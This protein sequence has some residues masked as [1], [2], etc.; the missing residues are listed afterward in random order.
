MEPINHGQSG[1][2]NEAPFVNQKFDTEMKMDDSL[3]SSERATMDYVSV[4]GIKNRTGAAEHQL[5]LYMLKELIDNGLD[6]IDRRPGTMDIANVPEIS[7]TIRKENEKITIRVSNSDFGLTALTSYKVTNIFNFNDFFSSKRN[8]YK[9]N[10]G[11]L[12]DALKEVISIPLA[13]A[14]NNDIP[15]WNEP[16]IIESGT[17]TFIVRMVVDK[18][19][20]KITT[21]VDIKERITDC[22][23]IGFTVVQVTLPAIN[24][25]DLDIRSF[26][27]NYSL[28]NT[29]VSFNFEIFLDAS[30]KVQV[31]YPAC[32]KL[33]PSSNLSSI[34]YYTLTEFRNLILGLD[35]NTMPAYV[36]LQNF[37]EGNN[38]KKQAVPETIGELKSKPARIK[39]IF[40]NLRFIMKATSRA[41]IPF[42]T[43]KKERERALIDRTE[44]LGYTVSDIKY[45]FRECNYNGDEIKFPFLVEVAIISVEQQQF[46]L[47]YV[48]GTNCSH[49][50]YFT[51]LNGRP[52]TFI[53]TTKSGKIHNAGNIFELLE[54]YGYSY[55]ED[56]CRQPGAIVYIN[57]ISP[58]FDYQNYGKT[59]IDLKP[60][61]GT[62]AYILYK[63][64]SASRSSTDYYE[65]DTAEGLLT[66]LLESRL[67]GIESEPSLIKTDRWTQ[68][69]VYYRL[70]PQLIAKGIDVKRKYITSQIRKVCE[71]RLGK[72]R[73]ELGIVAADR[74]QLY[75]R[76]QWYDVGL[77][78]LEKLMHFG[79]DM[80]IIEKE[81][82]A[83]VLSPYAEKMGIALLNTRGFL[84][85][86]ATMLSHL[87]KKNGCNVAILTDFDVSGLLLARKVSDVFRIGIDFET[88]N[89]FGLKP[90]DVEERY[91]A[92][93]NHM[94][95]LQEMGP[96]DGEEENIFYKNLEYISHKR[97]EIDSVLAKVGNERFWKYLIQKIKGRFSRRNYN[98]SIC[99][100]IFVMPE[101]V[102]EFIEKMKNKITSSLM[103]E[104]ELIEHEFSNF[105]GMIDDVREKEE[106]I[107]KRFKTKMSNDEELQ[108]I[109]EKIQELNDEI[110]TIGE[111]GKT[112]KITG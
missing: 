75:F 42:S 22:S 53:W 98:R 13:I 97:I 6:F 74:A 46:N 58:R 28:L 48:E 33:I 41:S 76:G 102:I 63:V 54:K 93:N 35:D 32:Q 43:C 7:I 87:S 23:N 21:A 81:G 52:Q 34:H 108:S 62:I 8:Q 57:L 45:G 89:Y 55:N 30:E 65:R 40:Q 36:I 78:E 70:R 4:K 51:F 50:P 96:T 100:P 107:T 59:S 71:Q 37:R 10:R 14:D 25:I 64:C 104:S 95:P 18:V 72:T 61:A 47:L 99:M 3:V 112:R 11:A 91:T 49:R 85:E 69:T 38:I 79:T 20:Q 26:L 90:K 29:H 15:V 80:L 106:E 24:N 73:A 111:D 1:A 9:V 103:S 92:E 68:S 39:E 16:L 101:I 86:Y 84:T 60:F 44:Q 109:L 19:K 77:D 2:K 94:K 88:L 12:G 82:V 66:E 105:E 83:E 5:V 67:R 110:D 17:N 27:E 56:K 31:N